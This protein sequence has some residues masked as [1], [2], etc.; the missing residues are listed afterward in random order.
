VDNVTHTLTGLM[1]SR[2]G[3]DRRVARA[4]PMMMIAANLPDIDAVA[5]FGGPV[6]YLQWHRSYPHTLL[7]A[8]LM[9]LI[10]PLLFLVFARQ[11]IT[12]WAYAGSLI[13]VLSHLALDWTNVYGIRML[14]PF[15]NRY[16]RL[17]ITDVIDPWILAI[18][19]LALAAP[20][21][22]RM[23]GSEIASKEVKAGPHR[24]W[25]WFA[26]IALFCYEGVRYTAHER[27][28][29]VMGA[30]TFNGV[31]PSRV[32]ALPRGANPLLW[33]GV[34]EGVSLEN[35]GNQGPE[36]TDRENTAKNPQ[37]DRQNT[38]KLDHFIT[39]VPV[40]LGEPF[41]P[42]AGR[43]DYDAPHDTA[44]DAARATHPFQVFGQFDQLP[45]WKV[46]RTPTGTLV[47]LIDLRFGTPQHPG[48]EASAT[49][50]PSGRV[51]EV[52]M[53]FGRA[54]ISKPLE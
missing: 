3:I 42:T 26:L 1:L 21:L 32:T 46:T 37:I 14:L 2:S 41:D 7:F 48:F 31:I 34:A 35:M 24:G 25:A 40:D 18:L 44:I 45:F 11:R 29:A 8:P 47:E 9:A 6:A 13:G 15:S 5:F 20:A 16:L 23:V 52:R 50:D 49:V 51:R 33:K 43:V 19:F 54:N 22:A 10:P 27:A 12:L 30:H 38:A 28:L 39:I 53:S 17:D 4:A 36:G